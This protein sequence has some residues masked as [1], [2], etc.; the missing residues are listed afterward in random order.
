MPRQKKIETVLTLRLSMPER[1]RN[2]REG[3]PE[4]GKEAVVILAG[5]GRSHF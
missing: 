3:D 2:Y 1:F 5:Y 4:T